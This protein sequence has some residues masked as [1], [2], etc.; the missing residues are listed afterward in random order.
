M[1]EEGASFLDI[2]GYSSRPGADHISVSEELKRILDPI[3]EIRKAHPEVFIS[4]DTFRSEVA[5]KAIQSGA[6]IIN[7]ISGGHLDA[8]MWKTVADLGAP[9]ITMHMKGT[10]Q[11]MVEESNYEDLVKEINQ[12]FSEILNKANDYGV[13]DI[14]LDPG[15][16]FAKNINQNFELL[17]NLEL[18]QLVD[19]PL[20]VGL[21]RKSMIY[22]TLK[23]TPEESLNGTT[24]LNALALYKGAD[25][26]RV[27]DVKSAVEVVQLI[28]KT[29][30]A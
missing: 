10:P 19:R 21:S 13:N 28:G 29:R 5:A 14:I 1:V 27:H 26:L 6:D 8:E 30:S 7:D 12:Y 17:N 16:G 11:T 9:F 3:M 20:L 24:A 15:F 23:C 2:G 18:L 25:I 4:V 22:K